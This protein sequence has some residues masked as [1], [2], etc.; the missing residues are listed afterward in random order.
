[1]CRTT[2][3]RALT[4]AHARPAD[5]LTGKG[6]RANQELGKAE[7]KP[8]PR[9]HATAALATHPDKVTG[10]SDRAKFTRFKGRDGTM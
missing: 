9:Q 3:N 5:G 8:R 10:G 6:C 2:V 4:A 7:W 1:M